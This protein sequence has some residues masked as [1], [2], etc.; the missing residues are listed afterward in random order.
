MIT[1]NISHQL[2]YVNMSYKP[3]IQSGCFVEGFI[4]LQSKPE[5]IL[6]DNNLKQCCI[7]IK[8]NPNKAVIVSPTFH[9]PPP[10]EK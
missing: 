8:S 9:I 10:K 2:F 4:L 5:F 7:M 3:H 6:G 1:R